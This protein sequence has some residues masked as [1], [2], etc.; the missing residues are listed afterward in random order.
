MCYRNLD[1]VIDV[2]APEEMKK[3]VG[4]R[5]APRHGL[6]E[7]RVLPALRGGGDIQAAVN[8]DLTPASPFPLDPVL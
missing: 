8:V 7:Y 1:A 3:V 4:G 5:G 6:T 2:L